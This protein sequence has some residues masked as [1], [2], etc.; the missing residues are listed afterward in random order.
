MFEWA[1]LLGL[2]LGARRKKPDSP[3][4]AHKILKLIQ[5]HPGQRLHSITHGLGA[6]RGTTKYYL[7]ILERDHNV[8]VIRPEG[9]PA[10]YFPASTKPGDIPLLAVLA[11][12]RV[13]EVARAILAHPGTFQHEVIRDIKMSRRVFRLYANLLMGPNLVNEVRGPHSCRYFPNPRLAELVAQFPS[14]DQKG[15]PGP[16]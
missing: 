5:G 16:R 4:L 13:L 8:I 10:R 1:A 2:A 6:N 3:S 9:S 15:R 11:R 7:Q 14:S 12:G